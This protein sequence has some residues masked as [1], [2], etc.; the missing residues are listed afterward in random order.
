M[1]AQVLNTAKSVS[2][3]HIL[4]PLCWHYIDILPDWLYLKAQLIIF[5]HLRFLVDP[6]PNKEVFISVLPSVRHLSTVKNDIQTWLNMIVKIIEGFTLLG[7][8]LYIVAKLLEE[9]AVAT[10]LVEVGVDSC[11][12]SR[13]LFRCWV[14]RS[15]STSGSGV[16]TWSSLLCWCSS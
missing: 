1:L 5:L 15:G 7:T 12:I 2:I 14:L 4:L 16:V 6:W 9:D 3:L 10:V 13:I 11:R 8:G